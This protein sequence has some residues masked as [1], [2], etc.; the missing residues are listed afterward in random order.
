MNMV[1]ENIVLK[2]I[3]GP[4]SRKCQD[5]EKNCKMKSFIFCII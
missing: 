3:F 2:I 1:F 5:D 4:K